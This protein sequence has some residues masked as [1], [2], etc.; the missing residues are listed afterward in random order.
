MSDAALQ[1]VVLQDALAEADARL[2]ETLADQSGRTFAATQALCDAAV[3]VL[4][5]EMML[6]LDN[7]GG[8]SMIMAVADDLVARS[9]GLLNKVGVTPPELGVAQLVSGPIVLSR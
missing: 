1:R 7:T 5:F 3:R 9:R 8:D 4:C 2:A 6:R